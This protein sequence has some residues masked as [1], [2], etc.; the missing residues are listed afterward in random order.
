MK[1]LILLYGLLIACPVLAQ[2]DMMAI[3]DETAD[4]VK[5]K[6]FVKA[7]FKDTRVINLHSL[8]TVGK[9]TLQYRISH[10]FG[11]INTGA[12]QFWGLDGGASIRMGLEYS[13]DGRF[14]VGLGRSSLEKQIDGFAKYRILRQT[15]D[16]RNPISI[17]WL[18]TLFMT[19]LRDNPGE[20]RYATWSNRLSYSHQVIIG[21]KFTE[22]LSIQLAPTVVHFNLVDSARF[23]NDVFALAAAGRFKISKRNAITF[24]YVYRL[25]NFAP[26]RSYY[27]HAG[28]GFDIETG[29]HVFQF[30]L[31]NSFGMIENQ[32]IPKNDKTWQNSGIRLGFNISRVFTI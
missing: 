19:T 24:E 1:K 14:S 25:N 12:Y 22:R 4:T 17:T 7:T 8:E 26:G 18:S 2:E 32:F 31:V 21:R 9:R 16:N 27:D 20:K 29:G 13:Y 11:D 30:M 28:I 15:V 5:P 10:R 6:E 23:D 3:M